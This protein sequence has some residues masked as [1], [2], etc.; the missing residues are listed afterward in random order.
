MYT[1]TAGR[2]AIH[3]QMQVIANNLANMNTSGFK[4]ERIL[5]EKE[6]QEVGMLNESMSDDISNPKNMP[7]DEFVKL[8]GTYTDFSTG[9]I[10]VTRN[11]LDVAID[12][13]GMFVVNTPQ[14]ERYTRS[15]E[16]NLDSQ[17][18][19]VTSG[20]FPVQGQ[21]GDI[22]ITGSNVAIAD[23]GEVTVN[24]KLVGQLRLVT[25]DPQTAVRQERQLFAAGPGS[26][27]QEVT[28]VRVRGGALESSNVNAVRELTDMI[29]AARLFEAMDKV[30]ESSGKM[31]QA[32]NTV[33]A[34]GSSV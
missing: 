30:G 18:R 31:S 28:D 2:S 14:G 33:F 8:A 9:E 1:A 24:G 20:G 6:A 3:T 11:P 15:G 19:L 7:T 4:A 5:F 25:L 22:I 17:G 27:P 23:N 26:S 29:F 13:E 12:G 16:F 34:R 32:R 10:Q 21:G